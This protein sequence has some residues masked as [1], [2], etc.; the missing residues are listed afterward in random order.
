MQGIVDPEDTYDVALTRTTDQWTFTMKDK[1]GRTG[2]LSF[3][4]P[5]NLGVFAV[6]E[7][8][9]PATGDPVL[10]KEWRLSA[11]VAMTGMFASG[12][13]GRPAIKVVFQGRGNSCTDASQFHAYS[14][15]V[16][17]PNASYT[18][19]GRLP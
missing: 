14:M 18:F 11:P 13:A 17:G 19:F 8:D 1:N 15:V 16:S 4:M 12:A 3:K 5:A 2:T 9:G 7:Q 10:Y 6:D